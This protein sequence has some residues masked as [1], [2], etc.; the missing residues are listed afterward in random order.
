MERMLIGGL[1]NLRPARSILHAHNLQMIGDPLILPRNSPGHQR[2]IGIVLV[3]AEDVIAFFEVFDV[4]GD[5]GSG[6][7][8]APP[9]T[10]AMSILPHAETACAI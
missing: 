10:V 7:G 4:G 6:I 8:N 2:A 5:V 1:E 9:L 3:A